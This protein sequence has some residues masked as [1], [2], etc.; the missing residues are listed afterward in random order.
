MQVPG[1]L[2][3][4]ILLLLQMKSSQFAVINDDE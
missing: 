2:G 4:P 3:V 1:L